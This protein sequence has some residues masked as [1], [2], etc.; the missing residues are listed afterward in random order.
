MILLLVLALALGFGSIAVSW[1]YHTLY[2]LDFIKYLIAFLIALNAASVIG[3][4]YN[5]YGENLREAFTPETYRLVDISYRLA[6]NFILSVIGGSMVFMLR[7]LVDEK[8]SKKYL[9]VL[10]IIWALLMLAFFVGIW[11]PK[12]VGPIPLT[13]AVN[14]AIDQIVQYVVLVEC[15]RSLLRASDIRDSVRQVWTRRY[16]VVVTCLWL[17]LIA[18]TFLMLTD[19]NGNRLYNLIS[20]LFYVVFNA[21]PLAFLGLFLHRVYGPTA[22]EPEVKVPRPDMDELCE[23]YGISKREK[24]IIQLV[25]KGYPN[26]QIAD[27]LCISLS[28]VKDHNHR[29]FRK[30]NVTSRTQLATM[31]HQG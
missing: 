10:M 31:F 26:K 11:I 15:F 8:P 7:A 22:S 9:M 13:V 28:T 21:L 6:A 27:E 2:R 23:R 16:L 18:I 4:F 14:I 25:C 20:A 19:V 24:D 30:L 3:I 17:S 12:S 5:Y 29:I 1:R